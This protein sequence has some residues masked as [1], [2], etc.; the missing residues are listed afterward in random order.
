M[1]PGRI[2]CHVYV[3]RGPDGLVLIDCGTPWGHERLRRNMQHWGLPI[4]QV[5]TVLLTHGHVDHVAGGY[6]F[7]QLGAEV[8]GHGDIFTAV[9]CQWEAALG[10]QGDGTAHRFDGRLGDGDEISRCGFSVRVIRTPGHTRGCLTFLIEVNGQRCLF[11]GDLIMSNCL[12]GWHGDPGFS[13][14]DVVAS[15]KRLLEVEFEHLCYGHGVILNDRGDLFRRA[16]ERY[17]RG[18]WYAPGSPL[19]TPIQGRGKA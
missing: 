8:F 5:R 13:A 2:D 7:K 15:M 18:L 6:L 12:P 17:E 11:S 3:L 14:E 4:E 16:I 19:L 1:T 10:L 9:E